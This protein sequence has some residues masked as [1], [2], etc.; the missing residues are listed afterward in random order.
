VAWDMIGYHS[1]IDMLT[2]DPY[3][4]LHNY[5]GDSTHYYVTETANHLVGS[6]KKRGGGVVLEISRLRK[7][8]RLLDNVEIY[9]PPLTSVAHGAEEAF[10]FHINCLMK[11]YPKLPDP[12]RN[13]SMVRQAFRIMK[14]ID[15][16][17]RGSHKPREIAF[18][19]SRTS[20]DMFQIYTR[21]PKPS[22]L[23]H[24]NVDG[25]Y[26][27][28]AQKEVMYLL[29]RKAYSFEFYPLEQVSYDEL[30]DFRMILVPFPFSISKKKAGLLKRLANDGKKVVI[31]SEVG[32][33]DEL[34]EPYKKP[35]LL[36]VIGLKNAPT[37]E[38]ESELAFDGQSPVL[39]G[40]KIEGSKFTLYSKLTLKPGAKMIACGNNRK[41]GIVLNKVGK[42]E[43]IFLGGEFGIR[44]P[45]QPVEVY[46]GH[47]TKVPLAPLDPGHV[48][49]M[50]AVLDYALDGE[51]MLRLHKRPG[52]DIEAVVRTNDQGD[53]ILFLINWDNTAA[54]FTVGLDLPRGRYR[55][56]EV[57]LDGKQKSPLAGAQ[58]RAGELA[59]M[60]MTLASQEA[61]VFH[62][63]RQRGIRRR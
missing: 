33:V 20:D 22:F 17:L 13:E 59:K 50:T 9:G 44:I 34:G 56:E 4:L 51:R 7:E 6:S 19:Y 48:E 32:A 58:V 57:V 8:Y 35:R 39:K 49:V 31:V 26:P 62:F 2:T 5:K 47:A 61:K 52:Q 42:G 21:D 10:Y 18:L 25:R 53:V 24:K 40:K 45:R 12:K 60:E 36:D 43:V 30:K 46:K 38:V 14:E 63:V 3:I 1:G 16:W 11:N 29:F 15:P 23:V 37:D 41:G 27:F 55:V 54:K 28:L